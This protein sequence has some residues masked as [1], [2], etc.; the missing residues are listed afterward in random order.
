[1]SVVFLVGGTQ[2]NLQC[3]PINI[4]DANEI[5]NANYFILLCLLNY[6]SIKTRSC[7]LV[8]FVFSL[9]AIAAFALFYIRVCVN[10]KTK[11]SKK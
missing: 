7:F 4:E 11:R 9:H 3:K 10:L 2:I 6:C 8:G 1:M 5:E